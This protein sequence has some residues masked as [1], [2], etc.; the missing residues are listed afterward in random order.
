[1][2]SLRHVITIA[3]GCTALTG[4]LLSQS[5]AASQISANGNGRFTF[6]LIG[7]MPYGPEGE[8]KFPSTI[9][10]INSDQNLS[11]VVHD[12]DI[13]N[14]SSLCSDETASTQCSQLELFGEEL[15]IAQTALSEITG[16]FTADDLLGEIFSRFCIGK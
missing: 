7:D 4:T 8:L 1:M 3:L 9:A 5:P 12:G 10:D 15:R 13:K 11:F 14:G 16:A 6:A 2:S